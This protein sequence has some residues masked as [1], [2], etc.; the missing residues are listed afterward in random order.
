M[1]KQFHIWRQFQQGWRHVFW[2]LIKNT[3]YWSSPR[4]IWY[5]GWS[6]VLLWLFPKSTWVLGSLLCVKYKGT[7]HA[8]EKPVLNCSKK[9]KILFIYNNVM[10]SVIDCAL[11]LLNLFKCPT[12]SMASNMQT[13]WGS[14]ENIS[15]PNAQETD[16][17]VLFHQETCTRF[18]WIRGFELCDHTPYFPDF[19]P[20]DCHLLPNIKKSTCLGSSIAVMTTSYLLLFS[21]FINIRM[22]TFTNRLQALQHQWKK[23]MK[24]KTNNI[25]E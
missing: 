12:A 25:E 11:C 5:W 22:K 23:G 7:N 4:K 9:V 14:Y 21:H 24:R 19:S 17:V 18:H 2:H 8:V 3:S 13:C 1:H 6:T 15:K 20:T 16:D 10:D